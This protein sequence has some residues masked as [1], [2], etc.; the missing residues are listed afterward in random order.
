MT[1]TICQ[2]EID[3]QLTMIE[4]SVH[5]KPP[6]LFRDKPIQYEVLVIPGIGVRFKNT[7][8]T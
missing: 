8:L 2:I 7:D 5:S 6:S 1:Y 3:E 4:P